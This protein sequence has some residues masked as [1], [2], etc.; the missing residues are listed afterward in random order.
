M[1]MIF[2]K[3]CSH[4]QK[5]LQKEKTERNIEL[6]QNDNVPNFLLYI[7]FSTMDSSGV[8]LFFLNYT[9]A[10]THRHS[11]VPT[12]RLVQCSFQS[13]SLHPLLLLKKVLCLNSFLAPPQCF[14]KYM[15]SPT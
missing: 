12:D 6:V 15:I 1:T 14:Y 2:R 10:H 13:A 5:K 11:K 8:R 4:E 9:K 3:A 7:K